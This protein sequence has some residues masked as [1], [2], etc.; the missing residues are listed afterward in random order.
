MPT[1][2]RTEEQRLQRS[3]YAIVAGADEAGR[4]AWA[5]PL[6]AAAVVLP[7]GMRI[8]GLRDSKLLSSRQR[9]AL[10]NQIIACSSW[11]V[12]AVSVQQIDERGLGWANRTALESAL[13]ALTPRPDYAL[14]DGL[15]K[16]TLPLPSRS[17]IHGD[18]RVAAIA[19]ASIIAKVTRDR[20]LERLDADYPQYGFAR[21]RGYGTHKHAD[22]LKRYGVTPHHRASFAPIRA[23]GDRRLVLPAHGL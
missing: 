3:G 8:S 1:A 12:G 17:I 13:L 4:G 5:G 10:Y 6:I 11:A 18:G 15:L 7:E 14:V 2:T 19:A 22:A 9:E 16:L 20:L 23:L 21:H